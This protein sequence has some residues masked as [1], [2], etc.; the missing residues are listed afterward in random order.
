MTSLDPWLTRSDAKVTATTVPNIYKRR[1]FYDLK[2]KQEAGSHHNFPNLGF[3]YLAGLTNMANL[4]IYSASTKPWHIY[5][6]NG[7]VMT[8]A[9]VHRLF[10][11]ALFH[12]LDSKSKS[13]VIYG[14]DS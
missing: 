11:V 3:R 9:Q 14:S 12:S 7:V 8:I 2:Y 10:A 4:L 5:L 13:S 6:S 1:K